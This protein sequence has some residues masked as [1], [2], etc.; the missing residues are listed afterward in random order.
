[1]FW[2]KTFVLSF[3]LLIALKPEAV[4]AESTPTGMAPVPQSI[5]KPRHSGRVIDLARQLDMVHSLKRLRQLE[6]KQ[7]AIQS[8]SSETIE[9][10]SIRQELGNKIRHSMLE[11][12]EVTAAIDRDLAYTDRLHDSLVAR[13]SRADRLSN[14]STF[15]LD[16]TLS[17]V[18]SGLRFGSA[19]AAHRILEA[20]SS[21]ISILV[22]GG[23]AVRSFKEPEANARPNMLAPLFSQQTTDP[24][25]QY[26]NFVW[27][28]LMSV[29]PDSKYQESRFKELLR[30]W[31]LRRELGHASPTDIAILSGTAPVNSPVNAEMLELRSSLLNDLRAEIVRLYRTLVELDEDIFL[32]SAK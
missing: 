15:V 31:R 19:D 18:K 26:N 29:A 20:A 3:L 10:L 16:G 11:V 9:I 14:V 1:M 22:P 30:S 23:T 25:S 5:S 2:F 21:G 32:V 7:A 4:L 27:T 17:A 13:R 6:R 24:K 8:N 28:Y 12:M